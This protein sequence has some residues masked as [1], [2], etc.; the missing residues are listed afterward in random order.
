MEKRN[1]NWGLLAFLSILGVSLYYSEHGN[2]KTRI[3]NVRG[4]RLVQTEKGNIYIITDQLGNQYKILGW[5]YKEDPVNFINLDQELEIVTKGINF[6]KFNIY[7][8]IIKL[9]QK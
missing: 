9:C 8:T 3:I 4:I 5:K 1:I 2:K 6:Q 7:P